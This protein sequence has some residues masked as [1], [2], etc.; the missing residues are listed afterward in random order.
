MEGRAYVR[1]NAEIHRWEAWA[2]LVQG[3]LEI[4]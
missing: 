4:V 1:F 2:A 3:R